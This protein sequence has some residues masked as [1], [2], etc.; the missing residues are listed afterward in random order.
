MIS[1]FQDIWTVKDRPEEWCVKLGKAFIASDE[2]ESLGLG[3]CAGEVPLTNDLMDSQQKTEQQCFEDHPR[4][5]TDRVQ[6]QQYSFLFRNCQIA[7]FEILFNL[8]TR[9]NLEMSTDMPAM[10][11]LVRKIFDAMDVTGFTRQTEALSLAALWKDLV[12]YVPDIIRESIKCVPL[13][14]RYAANMICGHP[15][16]VLIS[17]EVWKE[18]KSKLIPVLRVIPLAGAL[19][20][21]PTAAALIAAH[22][23]YNV[24]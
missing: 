20:V 24:A 19:F 12:K 6:V 13:F 21:L 8:K 17:N 18:A 7:I 10:F 2:V 4:H 9:Y 5:I 1:R 16:D 15:V 23:Y 11:Q 3:V 22:L 14:M